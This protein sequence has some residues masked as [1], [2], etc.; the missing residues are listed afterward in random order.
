[1]SQIEILGEP[2]LAGSTRLIITRDGKETIAQGGNFRI[3]GSSEGK[4]SFAQFSE[5]AGVRVKAEC[6]MEY[7][8]FIWTKLS[9]AGGKVEG[10]TLELP[11]RPEMARVWC[12]SMWHPANTTGLA[13]EKPTY[14]EPTMGV[15]HKVNFMRLGTEERGIQWCRESLRG[16]NLGDRSK[17]FGLIPRKD[18]YVMQWNFINT[19][20]DLSKTVEIE[21]GWQA[22][23]ARERPKGWRS[24]YWG[25]GRSRQDPPTLL[26]YPEVYMYTERWNGHWNYWNHW[27]AEVYGKDAPAGATMESLRRQMSS[28]WHLRNEVMNLYCNIAAGEGNSPEYRY[29]ANDWTYEPG[30]RIDYTRKREPS[31]CI[32][33]PVC[34]ASE[35]YRDFYLYYMAKSL[36]ELTRGPNAPWYGLYFDVSEVWTCTNGSHGCLGRTPVL[37]VRELIKRVFI[38]SKEIDPRTFVTIH[39]SGLPWMAHWAFSDIMIEG[40][41]FAAY[42]EGNL[43]ADPMLPADYTRMLT[44]EIMRAQFHSSLW[45]PQSMFL[46]EQWIWYSRMKDWGREPHPDRETSMRHISGLLLVHDN[47]LWGNPSPDPWIQRAL[48]LW[49]WDDEVEFLPYW[50]NEKYIDVG[51]GDVSP[52]MVSLF[53]RPAGLMTVVMNDSDRDATVRM[54]LNFKAL[55]LEDAGFFSVHDMGHP[56][57]KRPGFGLGEDASLTVPLPKRS[58]RLLQFI[59]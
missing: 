26:N 7:D 12:E 43:H 54:K 8:G 28:N 45:G 49:G 9:L 57:L 10:V 39:M 41:Q 19:P 20:T 16:W 50:N 27:N 35:N 42:W 17:G 6:W 23:P 33:A 58:Y 22:L 46:S 44:P 37:G 21:Y 3:T 52:V 13:P 14:F 4:I 53:R 34:P 31:E 51:S 25:G 55:G 15:A 47:I 38:A 5:V 2:L 1:M 29:Y 40:E 18:E 48:R 36:R 11:V 59:N 30:K 56:P 24:V 32:S